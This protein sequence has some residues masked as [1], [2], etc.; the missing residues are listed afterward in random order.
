MNCDN[1]ELVSLKWNLVVL[2]GKVP[3]VLCV[4][5]VGFLM[6]HVGMV[7]VVKDTRR[8]L[9]S[10]AVALFSWSHP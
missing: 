3:Y 10:S 2:I 4:I 9:L 7:D 1:W 8:S 6:A 5:F